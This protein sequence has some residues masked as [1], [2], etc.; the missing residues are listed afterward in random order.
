MTL[1][2]H[3]LLFVSL[4]LFSSSELVI[5]VQPN[6]ISA[7]ITAQL[8]INCSITNNQV[9]HLDV[10]RSLTLSRYDETL[11]EF[12]DLITL[13]A[14]T[15]NLSQLVQ[16]HHAQISFGNLSISLTLHNPTQFDAK[17]YRCKVEGDKTNAASSSIV[18]KKEV[19]YRTNMTA[20]IE[21]IRRLKVVEKND[22]CSLKNEE[23]TSYHQK[24]KLHFVGSSKVIKE[25]IEPLTLTCSLQNLDN[26]STV[27]FMYI[28]HGKVT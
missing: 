25:L 2:Q 18:A 13:E 19:E 5:D 23:L 24:T 28:L 22:Q 1:L 14:K 7:E 6:V 4:F 27:Q 21:E 16:L 10:I 3:F 9:Q 12:L 15:L 26:N 11:K 8:V 17:V 20:L